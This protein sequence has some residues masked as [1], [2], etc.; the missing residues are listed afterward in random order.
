MCL[1]FLFVIWVWNCRYC[2][3][4]VNS[5]EKKVWG[6]PITIGDKITK[7]GALVSGITCNFQRTEIQL[8]EGEIIGNW[9]LDICP[10][11][12]DKKIGTAQI[13]TASP[14]KWQYIS[15][16]NRMKSFV[17]CETHV[18][19]R[20]VF[21]IS[22]GSFCQSRRTLQVT[23]IRTFSKLPHKC[24]RHLKSEKLMKLNKA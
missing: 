2:C 5:I 3:L 11:S 8:L 15:F 18:D 12:V 16:D 19:K 24:P 22:V 6:Q 1:L 7:R 13:W 14:I 21:F 23:D 20:N 17:N 10:F 9:Y 4:C